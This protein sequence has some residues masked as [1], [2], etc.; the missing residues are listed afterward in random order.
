MQLQ[1]KAIVINPKDNVA[2]ATS[3]LKK[4]EQLTYKNETINIREDIKPPFKLALKI[5]KEG[6]EIIKYGEIIGIATGD[7]VPGELVHVHNVE[8][9]RGRGDKITGGKNE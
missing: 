4:G 6:D 3:Y 8:G 2:V 9:R 1:D 5:I 7:I